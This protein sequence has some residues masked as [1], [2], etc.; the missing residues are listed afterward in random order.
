MPVDAKTVKELREKTGL[1]MMECKKA[2][3][4]TDGDVEKAIEEL[5]KRGAAAVEKLQGRKADQGRVASRLSDDGKVG[6]VI[7]LRC[8]TEPVANNEDFV[9]FVEQLADVAMEQNPADEDAFLAATLSSGGTVKEGLTDLINKLRENIN[10]GAYSRMEADGVAQYIHFDNRHA[11]MVA[12]SGG[13]ATDEATA[14]LGKDVCMHVV[15]SKPVCLSRDDFDQELIE[16]EKEIRIAA[17]KND[18][19]NAK[20]PDE[21]LGKIVDGQMNKFVAE[22]CLLE[23][24]F[25]RDDQRRS[26]QDSVAA[27]G[28]GISL[29]DFAYIATDL[30][31]EEEGGE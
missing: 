22:Q 14:V 12:F 18:P 29:T 17:A 31:S 24:E 10:L 16:K 8:E 28:T 30:G 23:Q 13:S 11:A 9:A 19:K 26:V 6:A 7:T 1:P 2:L 4:E 20:K 27:S 15:F 21:I 3:T 25:I 5:R